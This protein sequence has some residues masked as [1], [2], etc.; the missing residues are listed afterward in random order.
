MHVILTTEKYRHCAE[1]TVK[2]RTYKLVAK[3][4][5][6]EMEVAL[7]DALNKIEQQAIRQNQKSTGRSRDIPRRAPRVRLK[8][9]LME[10]GRE[11]EGY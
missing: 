9:E 6:T 2:T 3:C 8:D 11:T 4:E 7:H 5:A 1:I 10:A